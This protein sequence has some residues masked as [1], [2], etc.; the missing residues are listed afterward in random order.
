MAPVSRP[1]STT[2]TTSADRKA[3]GSDSSAGGN[4]QLTVSEAVERD[5]ADANPITPMREAR[6]RTVRES[7]RFERASENA[8]LLPSPGP[9]WRALRC[10]P[11]F[12][13]EEVD[14]RT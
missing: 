6:D 7:A 2:G 4:V 8:R 1:F 14:N 11:A 9:G 12:L 3:S 5:V 10:L 13:C